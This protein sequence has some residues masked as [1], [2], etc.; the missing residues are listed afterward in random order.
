MANLTE[1][2]KTGN[3]VRYQKRQ[4]PEYMSFN[5]HGQLFGYLYDTV[6]MILIHFSFHWKRKVT[7]RGNGHSH[8]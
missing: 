5:G 8:W 2:K 4:K 3:N 1:Q 6:S 7:T